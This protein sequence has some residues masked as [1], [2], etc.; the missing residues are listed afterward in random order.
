[1]AQITICDICKE[2][3]KDEG[4]IDG[5]GTLEFSHAGLIYGVSIQME[6]EILKDICPACLRKKLKLV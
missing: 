4:I 3:I 5:S 6:S 1:M 2:N